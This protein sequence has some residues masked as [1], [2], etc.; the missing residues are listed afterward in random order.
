MKL[1]TFFCGV[2]PMAGLMVA[3]TL[4]DL[5]DSTCNECQNTD[6]ITVKV[7]IASDAVFSRTPVIDPEDDDIDGDGM[8]H[9]TYVHLLVFGETGNECKLIYDSK[10]DWKGNISTDDSGVNSGSEEKFAYHNI[11][12]NILNGSNTLYFVVI[13][14]DASEGYLDGNIDF[15]G[16]NPNAPA[17][18][19]GN[20]A[21]AYLAS[22]CEKIGY[23]NVY[24]SDQENIFLPDL[25]GAF[26]TK[27]VYDG[28]VINPIPRSEIFAGCTVVGSPVQTGSSIQV[29]GRRRV[30]GIKAYIKSVPDVINETEVKFLAIGT[31]P[32][33]DLFSRYN[34]SIP[35]LPKQSVDGEYNDYV[36]N[37]G[38]NEYLEGRYPIIVPLSNS[39]SRVIG[40]GGDEPEDVIK[41]Y[42]DKELI[43]SKYQKGLSIMGYLPS[44]VFPASETRDKSTMMLYLLD[45][46]QNVLSSKRIV[47]QD[48]INLPVTGSRVGTGI[49]EP[50]DYPFDKRYHYPI[51]TNHIYRIGTKDIPIDID[52]STADIVVSVDD[53][54]DE[55]YG[56]SLDE[57]DEHQGV[58]IDNSW[59][60]HD[61]GSL[62]TD[63][64]SGS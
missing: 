43:D 53:C 55:Y 12:T 8:Q 15:N 61:A 41:N 35:F 56:G 34:I 62:Q 13:G 32:T 11:G 5:P 28:T 44:V 23:E 17:G 50:S 63:S 58:G 10:I 16:V 49:I 57:N 3:C 31:G 14:L 24:D 18:L 51:Y 9:A 54:W 2:I 29:T 33:D 48:D 59:G 19:S 40:G 25:K 36:S 46:D 22:L 52:A 21:D 7:G 27:E 39:E 26:P 30:A 37:N 64:Q 45:K 6:S 4:R 42:P 1:R 47:L 20:S 60:E 38:D